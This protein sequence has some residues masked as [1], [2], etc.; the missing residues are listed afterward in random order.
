M[1]RPPRAGTA[2]RATPRLARAACAERTPSYLPRL[3]RHAWAAR[4]G[5][6]SRDSRAPVLGISTGDCRVGAARLRRL[7]SLAR[8]ALAFQL[9]PAWRRQAR[10]AREAPQ[11]VTRSFGGITHLQGDLPRSPTFARRRAAPWRALR[12]WVAPC[13]TTPAA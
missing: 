12:P 6:R 10:A 9:R 8:K 2:A 7:A 1:A 5:C 4:R 11:A 3:R 13:A